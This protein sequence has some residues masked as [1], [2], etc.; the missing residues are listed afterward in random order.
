MN[1]RGLLKPASNGALWRIT[2]LFIV[3][4][5]LVVS[6]LSVAGLLG[7]KDYVQSLS[8]FIGWLVTLF[9]AVLH[10]RETQK[11][12]Q[13]GR[14]EEVKKTLEM[15]AFRKINESITAFS[16][17][18]TKVT[19]PYRTLLGTLRVYSV[20]NP[21]LMKAS[22]QN[23]IQAELSQHNI[24]LWNGVTPFVLAIESHEIAVI[25]YDHLRKFIQFRVDAAHQAINKFREHIQSTDIEQLMSKNGLDRLEQECNKVEMTLFDIVM[26]LFDYRIE[27]MNELLGNVFEQTVPRR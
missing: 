12:N 14:R 3:A 9:L 19:T 11:E 8:A 4:Y 18:V 17:I 27:L 20:H 1:F 5:F 26:Y 23:F 6:I 24:M 13:N 7:Q 2:F 25:K 16:E 10:F 22:L 15:E 21:S